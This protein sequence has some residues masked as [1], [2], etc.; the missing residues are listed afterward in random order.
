MA[1]LAALGAAALAR[2]AGPRPAE[3]THS[4]GT[5]G[6]ANSDGQAMHVDLVNA[7]TQRTFLVGTVAGNP[8]MVV[9]NGSG[10]FSI[11][12]ADAIQGITRSNV[13]FAAGLQGRNQAASGQSVGVF[14]NGGTRGVSGRSTSGIGVVGEATSGSGI[15]GRSTT[16]DG[17]LGFSSG[18]LKYSMAGSGSGQAHGLIGFSVNQF[19]VAG[20]NQS[21]TNFAGFF[22]GGGAGFPGV[23]VDG[24][25]IATGTKSQAV[26]TGR[27]GIRKLYAVEATQP[28][29]EDF[30]SAW[31][32]NGRAEV[33]LDPV[34]AATVNTGMRYHVFLTPRSAGTTGLAVVAQDAG[35]FTVEETQ[36]G[37][38]SYEFDY[39][40][41][42]RGARARA[43]A[44]GAVHAATRP[45]A[46]GGPAPRD[47]NGRGARDP[48]AGG[49][50]V[51]ALTDSRTSA[52]RVGVGAGAVGGGAA[53]GDEQRLAWG[54]DGGD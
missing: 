26:P 19:G 50:S 38:G 14:G 49:A 25:F 33:R 6:P 36:G 17:I 42:A 1:G 39:R 54:G 11:G 12:Q 5:G 4:V 16:G 21:G 20:I 3:A 27:H 30:G 23:F 22:S 24:S 35:G 13:G 28:V 45:D 34:F 15:Q 18:D 7:G 48:G 46:A 40:V 44:T 2:L 9:F 41:M 43:D 51:D 52:G 47:P 32:E 10:P 31:L 29:F 53:G 37:R 8:P